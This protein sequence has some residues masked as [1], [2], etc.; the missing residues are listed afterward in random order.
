[1][2]DGVPTTWEEPRGP[3][4]PDVI[5]RAPRPV[6][7]FL[8]ATLM[9]LL[10]DVDGVISIFDTRLGLASVVS[11]ALRLA[12]VLA[13][14]LW[15]AAFFWRH[16]DG[17][18]D[19]RLIAVGTILAAVYA[20]LEPIRSA[21]SIWLAFGNDID[22]AMLASLVS[23][24]IWSGIGMA[25]ILAVALGLRAA[26][27]RPDGEES[28]RALSIVLVLVSVTTAILGLFVVRGIQLTTIN[29]IALGT[30]L[31]L[32]AGELLTW[33]A[34]VVV[35][36]AGWLADERPNR[37]W[38][39]A[40]AAGGAAIVGQALLQS[41]QMVASNPTS[42]IPVGYELGLWI[43]LLAPL[44]L[45]V[46]FALGLPSTA[47]TRWTEIEPSPSGAVAGE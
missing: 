29:V 46:A 39:L 37:A 9:A 3:H 19:A 26:R 45:L 10:L 31:V 8:A 2:T 43:G 15:G 33:S 25:A 17:W 21:F 1:M 44:I 12:A 13:L 20:V 40:A 30:N 35:A 18:R 23:G 32:Q 24:A 38:L 16:P 28:M 34:L 11:G 14:T 42:G 4:L 41:V 22:A 27:R 47:E 36:L 6:W 5:T 7:A